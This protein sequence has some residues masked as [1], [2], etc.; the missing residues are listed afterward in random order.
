MKYLLE[1]S[2]LLHSRSSLDNRKDLAHTPYHSRQ[3][4]GKGQTSKWCFFS[5]LQNEQLHLLF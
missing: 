4:N 3:R 2:L 5:L 1:T